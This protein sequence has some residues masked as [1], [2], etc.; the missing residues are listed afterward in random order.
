MRPHTLVAEGR[1]HLQL[2]ASYTV[3]GGIM[4]HQAGILT[5]FAALGKREFQNVI[6]DKASLGK[7]LEDLNTY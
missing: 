3:A 5:Q 2:K 1:T 4:R 6:R 7:S